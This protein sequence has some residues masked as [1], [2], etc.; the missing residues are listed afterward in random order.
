MKSSTDILE[1]I[2]QGYL[3]YSIE[4]DI[5]F[6]EQYIFRIMNSPFG[7]AAQIVFW[8][9]SLLMFVLFMKRQNMSIKDS[10]L[11]MIGMKPVLNRDWLIN[12]LHAFI[13]VVPMILFF[14]STKN[15]AL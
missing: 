8:S 12:L 7:I 1:Q 3:P 2:W 9:G 4:A 5:V 11:A 13:L 15:S 14:M 6:Q 10:L